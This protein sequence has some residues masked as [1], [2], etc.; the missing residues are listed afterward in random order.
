MLEIAI[1]PCPNDTFLFRPWIE[2]VVGA[3]PKVHYA[4][5][6]QLNE[7]A[8]EGKYPLIKISLAC[9]PE[10]YEILPVGAALGFNVGPKIIANAPFPL[11]EL[12]SKRIA[13]PGK[14]TT[15]HALLKRLCPVP[16]EKIFCRF[17]EIVSL[18]KQG[19]VDA[20]LI[21]HESRFTFEREG[22]AEIADLGTIW[23]DRF[24]LPLPLGG[25]VMQKGHLLRDE[26]IETLQAC[27]DYAFA[28]TEEGLPFTLKH[29]QEMEHAVV[30]QHIQTYVNK[31]TR[32]LSPEGWRAIEELTGEKV[33]HLCYTS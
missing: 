23:Y 24:L 10:G 8:L 32:A 7:W 31:E 13:I 29:A 4:D 6:Q 21:I 28:N 3:A 1:S 30:L 19:E 27:Y 18:L 26:V 25:L 16:K 22:F 15:A 14:H 2:G 11:E 12:G 5:I 33:T 20:G 17:D 9:R